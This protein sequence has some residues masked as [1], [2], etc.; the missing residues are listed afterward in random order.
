MPSRSWPTS[1]PASSDALGVAAQPAGVQVRRQPVGP[2]DDLGVG[3][4]A[5]ALDDEFAVT[6]RGRDGVGGGR[7]GELRRGV[8]HR[9]SQGWW[10]SSLI[11]RP[12]A[13]DST[14]PSESVIVA[15]TNSLPPVDG[16]DPCPRQQ[17]LVGGGDL[18]VVHVQVGGSAVGPARGGDHHA[19]MPVVE[20]RDHA[21]VHRAVAADVEAGEVPAHRDL[22]RS[23]SRD[24]SSRHDHVDPLHRPSEQVEAPACRR[25]SSWT[26]PAR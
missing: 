10:G 19:E 21:A 13:S 3:V 25:G 5:V 26:R 1:W 6:D 16:V 23:D 20:Q 12:L 14:L 11:I 7:D 8:G 4:A 15:L 2:L 18:S 24:S 17:R 22:V 9:A